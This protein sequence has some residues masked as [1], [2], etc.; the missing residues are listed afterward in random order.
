MCKSFGAQIS[1]K[2]LVSIR[3]LGT[4]V[5][6]ESQLLEHCVMY[7][8]KVEKI[9]IEEAIVDNDYVNAFERQL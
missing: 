8:R 6:T 5:M 2:S 1:F 3:L 7:S 4:N 9:Q